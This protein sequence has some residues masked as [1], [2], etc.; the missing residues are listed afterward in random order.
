MNSTIGVAN[1]RETYT[2]ETR[3]A[4]TNEEAQARFFT[5]GRA[6]AVLDGQIE[7]CTDPVAEGCLLTLRTEREVEYLE[8][9]FWWEYEPVGIACLR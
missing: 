4:L 9:L 8:T 6:M 3:P 1:Q 5:I 7:R 2:P